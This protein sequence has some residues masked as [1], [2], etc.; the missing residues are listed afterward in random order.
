MRHGVYIDF[1]N[2]YGS[3][4]HYLGMNYDPDDKKDDKKDEHKV[5]EHKFSFFK[6]FIENLLRI[7]KNELPEVAYMKA[8][9]EYESLPFSKNFETGIPVFLH[10]LGVKPINPFVKY[11]RNSKNKNASDISLALE[12]V[13][14]LIVK[15]VPI[16]VVIIISGDADFYPLASWIRENTD[17]GVYIASHSSRA[18]SMYINIQEYFIKIDKLYLHSLQKCM[19]DLQ[20]GQLNFQTYPDN[21]FWEWIRDMKPIS[22]KEYLKSVVDNANENLKNLPKSEC[23]EFTERLIYGLRRWFEEKNTEVKTGLVFKSWFPRWNIKIDIKKANDCLKIIL[24]SGILSQH[25]IEFVEEERTESFVKGTF[26]EID[27]HS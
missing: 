8:F 5:S 6:C 25:G 10:N 19:E 21:S 4:I 22:N 16:D 23:K 15:K 20:K 12:V 26:V 11:N 1:D 14:D 2:L 3:C 18:S 27:N 7:I 24:A 17:K 9:A 13:T